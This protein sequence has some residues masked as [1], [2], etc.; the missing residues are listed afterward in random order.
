MSRDEILATIKEE[1][2]NHEHSVNENEILSV[3][4][5]LPN[6]EV[7]PGHSVHPFTSINKE[8]TQFQGRTPDSSEKVSKGIIE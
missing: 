2:E 4:N 8:N 7:L 1:L 6:I 5:A 3:D